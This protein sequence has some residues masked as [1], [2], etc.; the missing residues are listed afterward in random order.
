MEMIG[1]EK[2]EQRG[3]GNVEESNFKIQLMLMMGLN[4]V[5]GETIKQNKIEIEAENNEK[6]NGTMTMATEIRLREPSSIISGKKGKGT[7]QNGGCTN[8]P[9]PHSVL[10]DFLDLVWPSK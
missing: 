1:P 7:H 2:M 4:L 10:L 3:K 9:S 8:L 5:T 6:Q